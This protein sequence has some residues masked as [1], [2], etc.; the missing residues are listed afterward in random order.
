MALLLLA[1]TASTTAALDDATPVEFFIQ[2][3]EGQGVHIAIPKVYLTKF[4]RTG[5]LDNLLFLDVVFPYM[6]PRE[7]FRRTLRDML[8][9]ISKAVDEGSTSHQ[10]KPEYRDLEGTWFGDVR[11]SGST[12]S[13]VSKALVY[14]VSRH[15]PSN[16]GSEPTFRHYRYDV[17]NSATAEDLLV[18]VEQPVQTPI[19]FACRP[20]S[21]CVARTLIGDRIHVS[22][23]IGKENIGQ[24]RDLDAKVRSWVRGFVVDCFEGPPL[25]PGEKPAAFYPCPF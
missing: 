9:D 21:S 6:T 1:L 12:P 13:L 22:Y 25:K 20:Q 23:N 4:Q 14:E 5:R 19:W 2:N 16:D 8:D 24:W 10:M 3:V 7:P 18:P 11:L 17:G 15:E